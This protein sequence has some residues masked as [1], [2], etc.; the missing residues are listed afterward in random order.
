MINVVLVA[1]TERSVSWMAASVAA[2]TADVASSSTS[3]LGSDSSALA[4]AMRCRCPPDRVSP[5]SPTSVP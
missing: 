1:V 2:S 5:R 3:T 4:S